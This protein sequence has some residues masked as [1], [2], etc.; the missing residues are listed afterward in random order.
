MSPL[1]MI[2]KVTDTDQDTGAS[3][4]VKMYHSEK[5]DHDDGD[6]HH[7]N[8]TLSPLNPDYDDIVIPP[9]NAEDFRIVAIFEEVLNQE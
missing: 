7:T 5:V 9:D 3:Y 1:I 6:W 2:F 4:T 8:I